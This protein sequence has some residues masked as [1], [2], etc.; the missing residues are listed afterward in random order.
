[1]LIHRKLILTGF[2]MKS[3]HAKRITVKTTAA[4]ITGT[5]NATEQITL[6]TIL[7]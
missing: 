2:S 6:E 5:F 4:E 7:A 1:M 3:I